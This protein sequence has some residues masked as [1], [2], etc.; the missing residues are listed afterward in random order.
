MGGEWLPL[1]VWAE[2]GFDPLEISENALAEDMRVS[3]KYKWTCYRVAIDSDRTVHAEKSTESHEL[4][5][6]RKTRALKRKTTAEMEEQLE[7]EKAAEFS[8]DSECSS[9]S[10]E[11]ARQKEKVKKEKKDKKVKKEKREKKEKPKA[12]AKPKGTPKSRA[13]A[14]QCS[15]MC[16]RALAAIRKMA[17]EHMLELPDEDIASYKETCRRLKQA[18][19]ACLAAGEEGD[20]GV[21][22][23]AEADLEAA[24]THEKDLKKKI[25]KVAKSK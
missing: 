14:K 6:N 7:K 22:A 11:A 25:G 13:K 10:S 18:E 23:L 9:D 21:S 17:G 19:K 2:R 16:S 24:K 12:K 5:Q 4:L 3:D 1:T 8:S 15:Q 20:D